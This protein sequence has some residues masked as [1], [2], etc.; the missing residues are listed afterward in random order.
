M[1]A[2]QDMQVVVVGLGKSGQAAVQFLAGYGAHI[3]VMDQRSAD[4][5]ASAQ[6]ALADCRVRYCL[7]AHDAAVLARA[8]LI[9]LS[10]G[11]DAAQPCFDA[12]RANGVPMVSEIE[13][14]M[15]H[16]AAPIIGVTGTNGK[17][18]VVSLLGDVF[19]RAGRRV[20]VAG[21][22]G[23]PVLEVLDDLARAD[24][25]VLEL[26]SYQIEI[27]P[28][29]IPDTALVLNVTPDHLDRYESFSE[30][31]AAKQLLTDRLPESATVIF[32]S[33]DMVVQRMMRSCVAH[34][35]PFHALDAQQLDLS[36]SAMVGAHNAENIAAVL[37]VAQRYDIDMAVVQESIHAFQG[38]PH[39]CQLV[40][41]REGVRYFDDSKGT[42]VA[43]AAKSLS[44]FAEPV[45]WIAGGLDKGTGYR[46]LAP[47]VRDRVKAMVLIGEAGPAME[48]ELGEFAG[49]TLR[50]HSM[51][52]AVSQA[53]QCASAGDVVLLSPACASQDMFKD[54]MERGVAFVR[55][56]KEGIET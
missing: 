37:Q 30:Y 54:F 52:D 29:L 41:Q 10:P 49:K 25:V 14:A 53:A 9:V 34:R 4:E 28:K 17:S 20:V 3:T 55:C 56:A 27:S 19:A 38:L 45:V 2:Y 1:N 51:E 44:S 7:G 11:V 23:T 33:G 40:H 16:I 48:R 18:T 21:N 24:I 5:L 26:S 47:V 35:Q 8:D 42:N 6:M 43:A 13:L 46:M 32:N 22:I 12:A 50:A 36:R 39:R 31:V 15:P